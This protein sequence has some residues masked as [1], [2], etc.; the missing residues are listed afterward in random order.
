MPPLQPP[1]AE[2]ST[3]HVLTT[4]VAPA[5]ADGSVAMASTPFIDHNNHFQ[6]AFGVIYDLCV[7]RQ[8]FAH[9]HLAG[10]H[11][12]NHWARR[13]KEVLMEVDWASSLEYPD[14]CDHMNLNK[15]QDAKVL[16]FLY[17]VINGSVRNRLR[18]VQEA[19]FR[20][21]PFALWELLEVWFGQG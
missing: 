12:Y 20:D 7:S 16:Q 15:E 14:S 19:T 9:E 17:R 4:F 2:T 11:N 10:S 1:P 5:P 8:I 13:V 18:D 3:A 21:Y 6:A